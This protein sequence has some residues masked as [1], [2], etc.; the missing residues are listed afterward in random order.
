LA[1]EGFRVTVLSGFPRDEL[2]LPDSVE[3]RYASLLDVPSKPILWINLT[4]LRGTIERMVSAC[5][6]VYIPRISY[7]AISIAKRLGRRVVV[8]LHDYQPMAYSGCVLAGPRKNG[9]RAA[10]DIFATARYEIMEWHGISRAFAAAAITQL[11]RVYSAALRDADEIVCVSR[12][13]LEIVSSALPFLRNKMTQVYNPLPPALNVQKN[14]S[15]DASLYMGGDSWAK[16]FDVF[17][18]SSLDVIRSGTKIR[19]F[20]TRKLRQ[21]TV[22]MLTTVNQRYP[23]VYRLVG[24]VSRDE[25]GK[26]HAASRSLIFPSRWEEPLPYAILEAMLSGTIPIAS[27]VGGVPEAL[28]DTPAA[29]AM[30]DPLDVKGC[31]DRVVQV[32]LMAAEQFRDA[33]YA[34][35]T[36]VLQRFSP[37]ATI[38]KFVEVLR[39]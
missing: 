21:R 26:I 17:L 23:G 18:R 33:S 32:H 2:A 29:A 7:P 37:Q 35:R 27:R 8:H 12:R 36:A 30:F 38:E 34:V 28:Q 14:P 15:A 11:N 6:V 25:L 10:N 13:Q 31:A 9:T 3:V 20:V 1:Q 22:R 24:D 19:F 5:D 39:A 16:G 4:R